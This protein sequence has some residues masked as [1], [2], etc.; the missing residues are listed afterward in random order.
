MNGLQLDQEL[1]DS[2]LAIGW[3]LDTLWK[4]CPEFRD[5]LA[6]GKVHEVSSFRF[7]TYISL[8]KITSRDISEGKGYVSKV[9][10]TTLKLTNATGASFTVMLKVPT[11]EC[12]KKLVEET[13]TEGDKEVGTHA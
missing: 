10:K 7:L 5:A 8:I 13:V 9:Y 4:R 6:N 3:L 2:G 12:L 11:N 1:A